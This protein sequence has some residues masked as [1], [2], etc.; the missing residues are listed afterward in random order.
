MHN[1]ERYTT[2]VLILKAECPPLY[3]YIGIHSLIAVPSPATLETRRYDQA[4]GG[5]LTYVFT[6]P[7]GTRTTLAFSVWCEATSNSI[8]FVCPFTWTATRI[9]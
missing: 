4:V 8:D 1:N 2:N 7:S 3:I 5:P 9:Y 6:V